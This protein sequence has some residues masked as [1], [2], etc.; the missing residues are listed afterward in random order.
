MNRRSIAALVVTLG[1]GASQLMGSAASAASRPGISRP[2]ITVSPASRLVNNQKITISGSGLGK[3]KNGSIVTWF[4]SECTTK[5]LGVKSLDPDFS[6][7]CAVTLVKPLRVSPSGRFSV[8]LKVATGKLADG[9]CGVPG[10]MTC[11]IAVGT[12]TGRHVT[13]KIRFENI[14]TPEPKNT[15]TTTKSN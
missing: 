4:V 10:H 3:S 7:H 6:P 11:V 12:A 2:H 5:A 9:D 15:T 1:I 13:A 8:K 14:G